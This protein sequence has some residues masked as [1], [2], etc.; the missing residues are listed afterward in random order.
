MN[1]GIEL[2]EKALELGYLEL[3]ALDSGQ[4]DTASELSARREEAISMAWQQ[5]GTVICKE[6]GV[7]LMELQALQVRLTQK[8]TELKQQL[9]AALNR[10]QKE[11]R[12]LAGYRKV[13]G[14]AL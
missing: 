4:V 12:R 11:S 6:Y 10:S 5:Q 2:L 13:V 7:K 8:A 9:A 3:E 14:Y 1:A